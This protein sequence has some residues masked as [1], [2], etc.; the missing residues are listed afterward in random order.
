MYMKKVVVLGG[1]FGGTEF[2]REAHKKLHGSPNVVFRLVSRWNYFLFYPMLHEVATGSVERSHITQPLR[3]VVDCC[4]ESFMQAEIIK[5]NFNEKKIVTSR[6]E[7]S[8]DYLVVALGV[9]PNDFGIPGINEHCVSFKSIA[10][11]TTVR[12]HVIRHFEAASH[13]PDSAVRKQLLSFVIVGGG[14]TGVELAGQLADM[15]HHEMRDLYQQ[16]DYDEISITLVD[17]GDRLLKQFH[18]EVSHLAEKRL[19]EMRVNVRLNTRVAS[20]E[21]NA[22]HLKNGEHVHSGL[23]VWAAGNKSVLHSLIDPEMLTERGGLRT[24]DTLQLVGH[25][26]VFVVGDN[27]EIVEPVFVKVPQTAQA[28]TASAQH[29]ARNF[30][31][32]LRNEPLKPYTFKSGGDIIP[33]GDWFA[34]AEIGSFRFFGA[35][36]WLMRRAVFIH[37]L[38]SRINRLKVTIDWALNTVLR[39]DTSEL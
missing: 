10:D 29:A 11:A 19:R 16:I 34:V 14:P 23:R 36:A 3:E 6:G 24:T 8:Y 28:A 31:A 4:M 37:R 30:V 20:C 39:R 21:A 22:L 26:E 7:V 25:P 13:E 33:I 18:P 5:I 27:M 38:T 1:G 32:M 15:L 35:I 17:A 2:Y 9:Q 12:N